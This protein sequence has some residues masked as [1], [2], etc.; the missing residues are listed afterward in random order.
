MRA[1]AINPQLSRLHLR[2]LPVTRRLLTLS[3]A[4]FLAGCADGYVRDADRQV[5]ALLRDR[6]QKALGYE[7]KTDVNS[8]IR[9]APKKK[10]YATIPSSPIPPTTASPIEPTR[11][12]LQFEKLGPPVAE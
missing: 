7:P 10:A 1:A 3:L 4:V 2:T 5:N 9:P 11:I 6:E 12:V 8:E